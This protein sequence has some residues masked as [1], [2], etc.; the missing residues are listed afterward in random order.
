VLE[1]GKLKRMS[2]DSGGVSREF[3][4]RFGKDATLRTVN[5]KVVP[6]VLSRQHHAKRHRSTPT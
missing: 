6:G 4:M 1:T 3:L 5:D 2:I